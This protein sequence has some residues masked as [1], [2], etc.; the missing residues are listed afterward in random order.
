MCQHFATGSG[1]ECAWLPVLACHG[2]RNHRT[3]T[4]VSTAHVANDEELRSRQC[5]SLSP[6]ASHL[7]PTAYT[8]RPG[9]HRPGGHA[10]GPAEATRGVVT[11]TVIWSRC[12]IVDGSLVIRGSP[13][14]NV[15]AVPY[16]D[17][18]MALPVYAD[19]CDMDLYVVLNIGTPP[20]PTS[21]YY[22]HYRVSCIRPWSHCMR[23]E[24]ASSCTGY[25]SL[26]RK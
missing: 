10:G 2:Q 1:V 6:H 3:V 12:I 25:L 11:M 21:A 20:V 5:Q 23:V 18:N 7:Q 4:C 14:G 22:S 8:C 13:A 16:V 24:K 26:G 17:L 15:S 19:L 9:C